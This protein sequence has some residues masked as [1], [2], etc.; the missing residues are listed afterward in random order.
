MNLEQYAYNC[1]RGGGLGKNIFTLQFVF[2][3]FDEQVLVLMKCPVSRE[4]LLISL[5]IRSYV[6]SEQFDSHLHFWI[7]P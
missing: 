3:I 2:F 5:K 1:Y 4:S 7:L 6:K